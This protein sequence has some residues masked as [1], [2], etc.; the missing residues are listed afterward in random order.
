MQRMQVSF[1][2]KDETATLKLGREAGE[3]QTKFD[4]IHIVQKTL[5]NYESEDVF[6]QDFESV[7]QG[8]YPFVIGNTEGV[9]DNRI[10]LSELHDPYTQKGWADN[11]VDDVIDGNWSLK[12]NTGNRG[13]NSRTIRPHY[14]FEA[15]AEYNVSFD[16]QTTADSYR[17]ISGDDAID[18]NDIDD[19]NGLSGNEHLSSSTDTN[20]AEFSVTGSD[21]GQTYNGN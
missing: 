8:I 9:T 3:G 2:A 16:Y 5:T 4:D 11:L 7:V 18:V 20:R 12:V 6:V 10:H 14:Q 13:R 17:F 19:A 1:T 15:G 21:N